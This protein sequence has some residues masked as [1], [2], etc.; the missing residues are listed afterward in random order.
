MKT[1]IL[2]LATLI[3]ALAVGTI[4][5]QMVDEAEV[6]ELSEKYS[7]GVTKTP[8]LPL[9][10]LSRLK[11]SNSYSMMFYS[12]GGISG[13]QGVFNTTLQYQISNPLTLTVNLAMLHDPG[14]LFNNSNFGNSAKIM[15]SGRLDWR[16][17]ENFW[18]TIGFETVTMNR[19]G[20]FNPGR[21]H[22]WR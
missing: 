7:T 12:G 17:S 13:Q 15:P 20:Y 16:P 4:R 5:G 3:L 9:L 2:I 10:D 8:S 19:Y 22:Y 18:M 11:I 1:K 6:R 14:A 21:Y